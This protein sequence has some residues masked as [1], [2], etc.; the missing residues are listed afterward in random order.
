MSPLYPPLGIQRKKQICYILQFLQ[1]IGLFKKEYDFGWLSYGWGTG[2]KPAK[3]RITGLHSN[4]IPKSYS[5]SQLHIRQER[6]LKM[7]TG[8]TMHNN[9]T[10]KDSL[11]LPISKNHS[12]I[13]KPNRCP[14][15]TCKECKMQYSDKLGLDILVV[16]NCIC[17]KSNKENEF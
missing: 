12:Y 16:C 4:W 15:N 6:K 13:L 14:T 7:T 3:T 5:P 10:K 1:N 11:S 8:A 9:N 2:R 17:H